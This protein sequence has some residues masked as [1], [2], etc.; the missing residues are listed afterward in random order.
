MVHVLRVSG[1]PGRAMVWARPT[2]QGD[3]VLYID[4]AFAAGTTGAMFWKPGGDTR[5]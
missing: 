2:R 4:R 1:M 3:T 5:K